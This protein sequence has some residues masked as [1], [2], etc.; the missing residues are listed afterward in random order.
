[1]SLCRHTVRQTLSKSGIEQRKIEELNLPN[2]I[3]DF[4]QYKDNAH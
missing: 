2:T 1:M 3:K 4:L